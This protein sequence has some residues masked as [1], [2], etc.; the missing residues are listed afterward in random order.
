MPCLPIVPYR[1]RSARYTLLNHSDR[2]VRSIRKY[3]YNH[4]KDLTISQVKQLSEATGNVIF[5]ALIFWISE[6]LRGLTKLNDLSQQE[7]GGIV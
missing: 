7:E 4:K 2:S 5:R 3:S 6:Y 1:T